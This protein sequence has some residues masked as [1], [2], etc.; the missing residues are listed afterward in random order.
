MTPETLHLIM[1]QCPDGKLDIYARHLTSAIREWEIDTVTRAAAF[2]GQ[3]AVESGELRWFEEFASGEAYEGRED[4]GNTQPGDG[5][6]YK[7]R[8]P[9]QLTGRANYR[10]AGAALGVDLEGSPQLASRPEVGFRVA[11]WYWSTRDLNVIADRLDYR[12]V[13]RAVNGG[14]THH[15]QRR[16][17]YHRA[18]EVLGA[19]VELKHL[20]V[21]ATV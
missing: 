16:A 20:H 9:I 6:R 15:R 14:L 3:L 12:M 8:G 2:L 11:G 18:L 4:L 17:Y 10:S 7:G 1:P 19:G 13:T 21:G 5:R